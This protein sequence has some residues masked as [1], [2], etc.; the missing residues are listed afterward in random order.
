VISALA[1]GRRLMTDAEGVRLTDAGPAPFRL[2]P[3]CQ[4]RRRRSSE[5]AGPHGRGGRSTGGRVGIPSPG[6]G[7]TDAQRAR[8]SL[9]CSTRSN[10]R[11]HGFR[12]LPLPRSAELCPSTPRRVGLPALEPLPTRAMPIHGGDYETN[13]TEMQNI[14]A[15]FQSFTTKK[16]FSGYDPHAAGMGLA[17]ALTR[18]QRAIRIARETVDSTRSSRALRQKTRRSVLT[19]S[20]AHGRYGR[21][22]AS[23]CR[24]AGKRFNLVSRI[25]SP[26]PDR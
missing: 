10:E 17:F 15:E 6:A 18:D 20:Q 16:V 13:H 23:V 2:M 21:V 11:S 7:L 4:R 8:T 24:G 9:L 25:G 3:Y 22:A 12:R 1:S 26:R 14:F 19:H 5:P